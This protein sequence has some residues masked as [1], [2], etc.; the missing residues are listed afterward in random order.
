MD[1]KEIL[2]CQDILVS[3]LFSI[4]A[5]QKVN[6]DNPLI[7]DA[8]I[9]LI[10][11]FNED[12]FSPENFE[13]MSECE[14]LKSIDKTTIDTYYI[15]FPIMDIGKK[16]IS[17]EGFS[18][19]SYIS[20]KIN[21]LLMNIN[22]MQLI[23]LDQMHKMVI[24]YK[25]T[26]IEDKEKIKCDFDII[27][28]IITKLYKIDE[29]DITVIDD[30]IN[31]PVLYTKSYYV[32]NRI[33]Y[34]QILKEIIDSLKINNHKDI[35]LSIFAGNLYSQY[36]EYFN[37]YPMAYL[38]KN[39]MFCYSEHNVLTIIKKELDD[40]TIQLFPIIMGAGSQ[41]IIGDNNNM[42]IDNSNTITTT[43]KK[44]DEFSKD[45]ENFIAF[46]KLSKPEWYTP[47]NYILLSIIKEYFDQYTINKYKE[48]YN[49]RKFNKLIKKITEAKVKPIRNKEKVGLGIMF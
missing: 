40:K 46:V 3:P 5:K 32:K 35:A 44:E 30:K 48:K 22:V 12:I 34:D 13:F 49:L 41:L 43:E 23:G 27:K 10:N 4:I 47:D 14:N 16:Y 2:R 29:K 20:S 21:D 39:H 42:T 28:K 7:L 37:K 45:I 11:L 17:N 33:E 24:P 8:A 15:M 9:K 38:N 6:K 18:S 19:K 1:D 36:T 25:I 31:D 26:N